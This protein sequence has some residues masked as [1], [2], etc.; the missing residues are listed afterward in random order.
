MKIKKNLISRFNNGDIISDAAAA[1][2]YGPSE[3]SREGEITTKTSWDTV[4]E[5]LRA[6]R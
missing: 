5:G 2:L 1:S 6:Q 4:E 3:A